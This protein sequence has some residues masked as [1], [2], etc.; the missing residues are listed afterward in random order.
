M[1][2]QPLAS[3]YAAQ[4]QQY[5]IPLKLADSPAEGALQI[6]PTPLGFGDVAVG[7]VRTVQATLRN[8]GAA[9]V[10]GLSAS[11]ELP[12]VVDASGCASIAAGADCPVTVSFAP[13]RLGA[14]NGLLQVQAAQTGARAPLHGNGVPG[15]GNLDVSDGG[16]W[17]FGTW[18]PGSSSPE[19][20]LALRNTGTGP[21]SVNQ[22][23]VLDGASDFN[24]RHT[25]GDSLPAGGTCEVTVSFSPSAYGQRVG[26]FRIRAADGS[27]RDVWLLGFGGDPAKPQEPTAGRL[28]ALSTVDFGMVTVPATGV[29]QPVTVANIGATPVAIR[30]VT[31]SGQGASAFAATNQCPTQLAP[32]SSCTVQL[33]FTPAELV[34]YAASL[35]IAS[36][37][38]ASSRTVALA[39]RGTDASLGLVATPTSVDFGNSSLNTPVTRQVT[40]TNQGKT[41]ATVQMTYATNSENFTVVSGCNQVL[42][43]N[44]S[45]SLGVQYLA[46]TAGRA[47]GELLVTTREGQTLKVALTGQVPA[48]AIGLSATNLIFGTAGIGQTTDA[49]T[50]SISN[51]GT[52]PLELRDVRL[53]STTDFVL[54]NNGCASSLPAGGSCSVSVSF[55]PS[56]SGAR[57]ANLVVAS[58]DPNTP[59]AAVRLYGTGQAGAL[60][61]SPGSA[62]FGLVLTGQEAVQTFTIA[63]QG[64]GAGRVTSASLAGTGAAAFAVTHTCGELMQAGDE[65]TATVTFRPVSVANYAATLQVA[66]SLGDP[67]AVQLAG[68]GQAANAPV[69]SIEPISVDFGTALVNQP[70][71]QSVVIRNTGTAAA[72][73]EALTLA[74]T[75]AAAFTADTSCVGGLAIGASCSV[76]L[77]GAFPQARRY[78]AQLQVRAK[79]LAIQSA[80]VAANAVARANASYVTATPNAVDFGT[81][82][83]GMASSQVVRFSNT[84]SAPAMLAS[85]AFSDP[86]FS[87]TSSCAGELAAGSSCD[88]VVQFRGERA[89]QG[90]MTIAAD[91]GQHL[92]VSLGGRT[93]SASLAVTPLALAFPTVKVGD[94]SPAQTLS[95]RNSGSAALQLQGVAIEGIGSNEYFASS[96]C[97]AILAAGQACSAEVSFSPLAGGSRPAQL[98]LRSNA[99]NGEVRVTLSGTGN[100][101]DDLKPALQVSP[102]YLVFAPTLLGSTSAA[103]DVTLT[104]VGQALLDIEQLGMLGTDEFAQSNSCAEA[105]A[106][107]QSCVVR[108]NFTPTG[109]GVRSTHLVVV[110]NDPNSPST[111]VPL[112]G[113]GQDRGDTSASL[114]FSPELVAFAPVTVGAGGAEESVL[115]TNA[116]SGVA[117]ISA[118]GLTSALAFSQNNSCGAPLQPGQSC[119]V[120]VRFAPSQEGSWTS[121]LAVQTSDGASYEI[122]VIGSAVS[123]GAEAPGG[124]NG[125][126]SGSDPGNGSGST[127]S[128][129]VSSSSLAFG[130]LQ[131]GAS[132]S[133]VLTLSNPSAE[134][135]QITGISAGSGVP[136]ATNGA[137]QGTLVAGQSCDVLVTFTGASAGAYGGTLQVVSTAGTAAVTLAA[138]VV[139]AP[140]R[141]DVSAQQLAFGSQALGVPSPAQSVTLTHAGGGPVR[142]LSTSVAG[143][144]QVSSSSCPAV[145]LAGASCVVSVVH[146]PMTAGAHDGSLSIR[147]DAAD[148]AVRV[149]GLSGSGVGGKLTLSPASV[150]FGAMEVGQSQSRSFTLQNLGPASV[151]LATLAAVGASAGN[152]VLKPD[153]P[154]TLTDGQAC[155]ITVTFAPKDAGAARATLT[156]T[157]QAGEPVQASLTGS[158]PAAHGQADVSTLDFGVQAVGTSSASKR[159]KLTNTGTVALRFYDAQVTVGNDSFGVSGSCPALLAVGGSCDLTVTF[160]PSA[161]GSRVGVLRLNTARSEGPIDIALSGSGVATTARVTPESLDFGKVFVGQSRGYLVQ[162]INTGDNPLVVRSVGISE[163]AGTKNWFSQQNTCGQAIPVGSSCDVNVIATPTSNEQRQANVVI[164]TTAGTFN[165]LAAVIGASVS[166]YSASPRTVAASGGTEVTVTGAGFSAASRVF[167]D[168]VEAAQV[169]VVSSSQMLVRIPAHAAGYAAMSV[170]EDGQVRASLSRALLYVAAPVLS[171][172]T[173]NSGSVDGGWSA[174]LSGAGF[175]GLTGVT[176]EGKA[177]TVL[178]QN[179]SSASIRVPARASIAAGAVDVTVSTIAG[180]ATLA[181]GLTYTVAPAYVHIGPD[182]AFGNLAEGTATSKMLTLENRG[183]TAVELGGLSLGGNG[184]GV[185]SLADGGSCPASF[186]AVMAVGQKCSIE[187]RA[188]GVSQGMVAAYLQVRVKAPVAEVSIGLTAN[189]VTPDYGLSGSYGA[190]NAVSGNFGT[191]AAMSQEGGSNTPVQRVVYLNNTYRLAQSQIADASV[192]ISGPDARAFRIVNVQAVSQTGYF[193]ALSPSI[194]GNGLMS[195]PVSADVGN[196]G[197]PHLAVTLEY[198]PAAQGEHNAQMSIRYNGGSIAGLPLY[199]E[200]KYFNNAALSGA[201]AQLTAPDGNLGRVAFSDTQGVESG[202]ASRTFYIRTTDAVGKLLQVNRLRVIGPDASSFPIVSFSKR[203]VGEAVPALDVTPSMMTQANT[204]EVLAVQVQFSPARVGAHDAQLVIESNADNGVLSLALA[205]Q[206]ARD[207]QVA[208]SQGAGVVPLTDYPM[209]GLAATSSKTVY[210]RNIGTIGR[211]QFQGMQVVGSPAFSLSNYGVARGLQVSSSGSLPAGTRYI[212]DKVT[213]SDPVGGNGYIDGYVTMQ[214]T[215]ATVGVHE[216]TVTIWH[217]GPGGMTTFTVRGEGARAAA[218]LSSSATLPV[219]PPSGDFGAATYNSDGT[220]ADPQT[221]TFNV[222]NATSLG[223]VRVSRMEIVGSDAEAFAFV[224]YTGTASATGQVVYPTAMVQSTAES[225]LSLQVRFTPKQRGANRATLLVYH[226]AMNASPLALEL[227]GYGENNVAFELSQ[228]GGDTPVAVA[229]FPLAGVNTTSKKVVY[230]RNVGTRGSA[231]FLGFKVE[232]DQAFGVTAVARALRDGTRHGVELA[233]NRYAPAVRQGTFSLKG[234]DASGTSFKDFSLEVEYKPTLEGTQSARVTILHDGPGGQTSFDIAGEAQ[235]GTVVLSASSSSVAAISGELG[236]VAKSAVRTFYALNETQVAAPKVTR[237]QVVGPDAD[238]FSLTFTKAPAGFTG[239]DSGPIECSLSGTNYCII[240]VLFA[241]SRLGEHKATLLV[242]HDGRNDALSVPLTVTATG[243]VNGVAS[244]GAGVIPPPADWGSIPM[245]GGPVEMPVFVRAQGSLGAL[246]YTRVALSGST[247]FS[248]VGAGLV[249]AADAGLVPSETFSPTRSADLALEGAPVG[250]ANSDLGVMLRF[251]PTVN[252]GGTQTAT[253]TVYFSGG[254]KTAVS[255]QV[256]ATP[257]GATAVWSGSATTVTTPSTAFSTA[258]TQTMRYYIHNGSKIG[259]LSVQDMATSNAT[260]TITNW[261]GK[262][263]A[264]ATGTRIIPANMAQTNANTALWVDVTFTPKVGTTSYSNTLTITHNGVGGQL[265]LNMSGANTYNVTLTPSVSPITYQTTKYT[266]GPGAGGSTTITPTGAGQL[267]YTKVSLAWSSA[268]M[269]GITRIAD[270]NGKVLASFTPESMTQSA[271]INHAIADVAATNASK[272][273]TVDVWFRG[274]QSATTYTGTLTIE[275]NS[276]SKKIDIPL[277][278]RVTG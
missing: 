269:F 105:L 179:G 176:V 132:A 43:E 31:I 107:Q 38:E 162:V 111:Y 42:D 128:L 160:T 273:L 117:N 256:S 58:N 161:A 170:Q 69:L 231:T 88:L 120:V 189:V 77:T 100:N 257:S 19:K 204:G 85:P 211:V 72:N 68:S 66:S 119:Q 246:T 275:N 186:P 32:Y 228:A 73:I 75:D 133:R 103:L 214:F 187:V 99:A 253:V 90:Q 255:F 249:S 226:D 178:S 192:E 47:D 51:T 23:F 194:A 126:E 174:T 79:D 151:T 145:L 27:V 40:L 22:I 250:Q 221:R 243:D 169:T 195:T 240:N 92:V 62:N 95:L 113:L 14:A 35:N 8:E 171:S 10:T 67:V 210:L 207:V 13:S 261:S 158:G 247:S 87:Q 181:G 74:G 248:L 34:A 251:D 106:P 245:N 234:T 262:G 259:L 267:T 254:T 108:V 184:S 198:R 271:T 225:A 63:N 266:G 93:T 232:G 241:A 212:A 185:F 264:E 94:S 49:K 265:K 97:P 142:L 205:G 258:T 270:G 11:T 217:D 274:S 59:T 157:P 166:I 76:T 6:L 180:T 71:T 137:C 96:S 48:G 236:T 81:V 5:R 127:G 165:V 129:Q 115:L 116:G 193:K 278:A 230:L 139:A 102:A 83:A 164:V 33:T 86:A 223:K 29:L 65:C 118:L 2:L 36:S 53:D 136:F 26:A 183:T 9:P 172:V 60:A 56:A 220:T 141:L 206:G 39:G 209:T 70:A 122:T 227:I 242:S 15:I 208:V 222:L 61:V 147:S 20:V 45:C 12:F 24:L 54:A 224:S 153:C 30:G 277:S 150:D 7:Q 148:G 276:P 175:L 130:V 203:R 260:F 182:G 114:Q 233:A 44:A 17:N 50:V 144:F 104:N 64:P 173:P 37:D 123:A 149:I 57:M 82:D 52:A 112:G 80:S 98:V 146:A 156:V 140:G 202:V 110:S 4:A 215:P 131:E 3:A 101:A 238:A 213:A 89:V 155:A 159:V 218:Q 216:A 239:N 84:G 268:P 237:I 190:M 21:I 200:A 138:S 191:V 55:A 18:A 229:P 168:S 125:G 16:G 263:A 46:Q 219:N 177:A 197:Y 196:G 152:F 244:S 109:S 135:V 25:C 201:Q 199:G 28:S 91:N 134:A 41:P 235:N 124:D 143:E 188:S 121:L 272:K 167:V 78:S 163:I 1:A 252:T 154:A